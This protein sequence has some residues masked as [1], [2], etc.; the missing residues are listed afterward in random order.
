MKHR[1]N[2]PHHQA[3]QS[4]LEVRVM[5]PRIAWLT[6]LKCAGKTLQYACILAFLA[7]IAAGAWRGI[8]QLFLKNPDFHLQVIA[9][10][11][12]PVIDELGVA[13]AAGINLN[14]NPSLFDIDVNDVE[15]K[16]RCLPAI[17]AVHVERQL[18]C[19]LAITVTPRIPKAWLSCPTAGITGTRRAGEML[20]DRDGVAYPCPAL[21][22]EAA[23]TLPIISVPP[24][25]KKPL[26][27]GVRIQQPEL[28]HCLLLLDAACEADPDAVQWIESVRQVNEWSLLL[29]TRQGTSATFGLSDHPRQIHRLRAALDHAGEKGYLIDTINLIP[30]YNIPITLRDEPA[31]APRAIPV[32]VKDPAITLRKEPAPPPRAIPVSVK[33]PAN[34]TN[35]RRT[36][37]SRGLPKRN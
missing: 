21:Q 14:D 30:K 3:R 36:R 33:D 1:T 6:F 7:G 5:S 9:L 26:Q 22:V 31:P 18:P 28:D 8:Q 24:S 10:N 23:L 17:A 16:L 19:T 37:D 11:P 2:K 12:N 25:D 4:V 15:R 27:A 34:G 13:A 29:V 35:N 32:S 20:L